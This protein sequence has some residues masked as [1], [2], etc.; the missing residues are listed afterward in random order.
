MSGLDITKEIAN[1]WSRTKEEER[2]PYDKLETE[3]RKVYFKEMRK[4]KDEMAS[5]DSTKRTDERREKRKNK[6][7]KIGLKG[8]EGNQQNHDHLAHKLDG[9][10]RV[11]YQSNPTAIQHSDQRHDIG[12]QP[13][14]TNHSYMHSNQYYQS[15]PSYR[16][17]Q[18][19]NVPLANAPI[20]PNQ[21]GNAANMN[22]RG[23]G[24]HPMSKISRN[25]I[26]ILT[27]ILNTFF[28]NCNRSSILQWCITTWSST[29]S[30]T[31][32]FLL[33]SKTRLFTTTLIV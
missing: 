4:W 6:K 21:M 16:F 14:Y 20:G 11:G 8:S 9:K 12:Y 18:M 5:G 29:P 1:L 25:A 10:K 30:S 26:I 31:V 28:L 13:D 2:A 27:I 32:I 33:N 19:Q 23:S 17:G 24:G 15:Q 7:R 22:F 3:S